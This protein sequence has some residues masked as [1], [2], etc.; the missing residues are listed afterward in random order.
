MSSLY[1]LQFSL[2]EREFDILFIVYM[3][4]ILCLLTAELI[5]KFLPFC[6]H[7]LLLLDA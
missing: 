3:Y 2:Y 1:D 4:Y 7:Y 6:F 5:D